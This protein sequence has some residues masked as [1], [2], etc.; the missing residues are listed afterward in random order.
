MLDTRP[1]AGRLAY[2]FLS[3]LH[4]DDVISREPKEGSQREHEDGQKGVHL[5]LEFPNSELELKKQ[6]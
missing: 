4:E 6:L 3:D 5:L 2:H 1:L